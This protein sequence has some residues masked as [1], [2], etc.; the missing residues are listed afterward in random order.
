[1][2]Q[3]THQKVRGAAGHRDATKQFL[4]LLQATARR[5]GW[6]EAEAMTH[7]LQAAS[8]ALVRRVYDAAQ[9]PEKAAKAEA[10]YMEVVGRCRHASDT[11]QGLAQLLAIAQMALDAAP[12]DFIGPIYSEVLAHAGA[13]QFF[14][15]W[16]LSLLMAKLTV[17]DPAALLA[18]CRQ[19]G[20][21][22]I[23]LQEPASGV[24][25]MCLA[26]NQVLREGGV[27]PGR[28]AHWTTIDV[29]FKCVAACYLQ[30]ELTNSSAMVMHGDALSLETWDAWPTSA[31]LVYP[32]RRGTA[33]VQEPAQLPLAA[34]PVALAPAP[35]PAGQLTFDF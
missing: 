5:E 4:Q 32:K 30:L 17:A 3:P 20:A 8:A 35:A 33:P 11:M 7:W 26:M 21:N 22:H 29:D 13:G 1:M 16:E 15:P 28:D 9:L 19:A 10:R 6:R 12:I 27:D 14:T 34:L 25:G 2:A 23:A 24:G 31:A 18:S